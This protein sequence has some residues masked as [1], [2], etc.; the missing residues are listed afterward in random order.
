MKKCEELTKDCVLRVIRNVSIWFYG[1][2]TNSYGIHRS[3]DGETFVYI[4][5]IKKAKNSQDEISLLANF[6]QNTFISLEYSSN[7]F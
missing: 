3:S 6:L 1:K 2:Y 7:R 5:D 4:S